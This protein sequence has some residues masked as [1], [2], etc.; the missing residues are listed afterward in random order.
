MNDTL[1]VL[2]NGQLQANLLANDTPNG[3]V[4]TAFQNP[5]AL[6]GTVSVTGGGQLTYTPPL[7]QANASDSFTYTLTNAAGS[8]TATVTVQIGARGFFVKN[9]APVGGTGS[10][11]S[12]FN[13]L[14]AAV[15]AAAPVNG[16]EI[17]VFRG[18]GTSTGLNT[19]VT[20]LANQSLRAL[21]GNVPVLGGPIT[22]A[23]NTT[24]AGVRLQGGGVVATGA[25]NF[26]VQ[27]CTVANS[28]GDGVALTDLVGTVNLRNNSFLQNGARGLAVRQS[29]GLLNLQLSNTA[30][31]DTTSDGIFANVTNT[32]NVTWSETNTT[33][34]RAG[35]GVPFAG[36]SWFLNTRNTGALNATW[37][38]CLSDG[39][40]GFGMFVNSFDASNCTLVFDQGIVRNGP[41]RGFLLEASDSST[42][43]ARVSNTQTNQNNPGFGFEADNGNFA[44]MCL[45]LV[46]V[47]S[48]VYRLLNNNAA[49]PYNIEN[50]ANF[51]SENTGSITQLGT[52]N[53]VPIG[54][55]GIP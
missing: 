2:G 11:A 1:Q 7:N 38:Q 32:G 15:A 12:P 5:S 43:K 20:L 23:N 54:S 26:T 53:S 29:A 19:P 24:L 50:F 18:D 30:V 52:I 10:Q 31:A 51:A 42:F 13:T 45:R 9:D 49:A 3:A 37:S 16:A 22:M 33:V 35:N 34:N 17:V 44:L 40:Q 4:V 21:D 46:N 47:T 6:G 27:D 28:T 14:A 55:C 25:A 8:A 39:P 41:S 48:D 36:N